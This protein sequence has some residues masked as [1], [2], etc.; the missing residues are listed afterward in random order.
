STMAGIA[1]ETNLIQSV[2]AYTNT[3]RTD[4]SSLKLVMETYRSQVDAVVS[5]SANLKGVAAVKARMAATQKGLE[6]IV[7]S[8]ISAAI[9]KNPAAGLEMAKDPELQKYVGGK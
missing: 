8:A 4:P 2:N 6:A 9:D 3:V 5:T 7:Q 1:L